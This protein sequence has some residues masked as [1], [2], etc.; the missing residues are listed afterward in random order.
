M[1]FKNKVVWITGASSGIGKELAIQLVKLE[2]ILILTSSNAQL[3]EQ[4]QLELNYPKIH[5]LPFDLFDLD[6]IPNLVARAFAF[7][8][9]IDCIIQSAGISQRSLTTETDLSVYKKLMDINYFAPVALT[10]AVLPRFKKQN[11]GNI[12]VIS[13]IAGLIGFPL[14][15][16]YAASKH[17]I[18]GYLE[19]LQCELY[20]SNI[21][22][23]IVY[24]GRIDTNI[25]KNALKGNGEQFGSTDENNQVGM[26]VELCAKKIINGIIANKKSIIIVKSERLLFWLWWFIPSIYYKIA[27]SKGLKK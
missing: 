2:A 9:S 23:S 17:A 15:S 10:Q 11:K 12:T 19:T 26:K 16:G 14:R 5:I 27:Y 22:V 24:P 6:G 1:H 25:S 4:L 18:K 20:K 8:G 13:S 21:T 3:L 7:Q